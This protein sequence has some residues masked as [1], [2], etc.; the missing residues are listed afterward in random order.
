M[1]DP[2]IARTEK[3]FDQEKVNSFNYP[4]NSTCEMIQYQ[5]EEKVEKE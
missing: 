1:F 4:T 2:L 3:G 5:N